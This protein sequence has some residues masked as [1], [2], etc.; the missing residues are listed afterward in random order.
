M[1]ETSKTPKDE[2]NPFRGGNNPS[3]VTFHEQ[4]LVLAAT[5]DN[6][7]NLYGSKT[8]DF[9]GF[10]KSTPRAEDDP[11][12][13]T[14]ASGSIDSVVWA[15]SFGELLLGHAQGDAGGADQGGGGC[16]G[17]VITTPFPMRHSPNCPIPVLLPTCPY[18]FQRG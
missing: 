6:P 13:F 5:K 11:Y 2:F 3:L 7:Q 14:I 15:A 17:H 12:E 1:A 10:Y 8:G 4:R 16:V 18:R 9:S